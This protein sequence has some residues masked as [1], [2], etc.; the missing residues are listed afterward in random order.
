MHN[1]NVAIPLGGELLSLLAAV[2]QILIRP[3]PAD[4]DPHPEPADLDPDPRPGQTILAFCKT[5]ANL[6]F[7][8]GPILCS[9]H[10]YFLRKSFEILK[11]LLQFSYI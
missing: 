6:S 4:P 2:L 7:I 8:R 9:L 10:T 1:M 11:D 3:E 5:F